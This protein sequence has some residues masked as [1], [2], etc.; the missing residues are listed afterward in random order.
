MVV[1][2][3]VVKWGNSLGIPI[4]KAVADQSFQMEKR[5]ILK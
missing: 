2:S 5:W 3:K 4:Q 1:K